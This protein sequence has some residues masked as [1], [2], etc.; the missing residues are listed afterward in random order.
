MI[1]CHFI[2]VR[3]RYGLGHKTNKI[4]FYQNK[5]EQEQTENYINQL[6]LD[7]TYTDIKTE[8]VEFKTFYVAENYHQ[9]YFITNPNQPYCSLIINPKVQKLRKDLNKYYK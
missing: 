9:N 2:I 7:N 5:K 6:E 8:V 3:N 1:F 4:V